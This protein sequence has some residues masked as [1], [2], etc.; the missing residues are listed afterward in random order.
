MARPAGCRDEG[1]LCSDSPTRASDPDLTRDNLSTAHYT[2]SV[3]HDVDNHS[4]FP[5]IDSKDGPSLL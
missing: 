2:I 4:V 5:D 3:R 1:P